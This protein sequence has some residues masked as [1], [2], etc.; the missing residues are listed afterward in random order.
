MAETLTPRFGFTHWGDSSTD[1]PSM[2]EFNNAFDALESL[3]AKDTQG[4]LAARPVAGE[5]QR[6]YFATD[7]DTLYRDNGSAWKVVGA[8]TV[9]EVV[10][11]STNAAVPM[12]VNAGAGQ[13]ADLLKAQVN[14][15]DKFAVDKD[16]KITAGAAA[17]ANVDITST[18]AATRGLRVT[19]HAAQSAD[20]ISARN[21][22]G[23]DQFAVSPTGAITS[24]F[25][26]A[27][28][29]KAV[30]GGTGFTTLAN[31]T[32]FTGQP[33]FEVRSTT[34]GTGTFNDSI[35][36]RHPQFDA[37]AV[38]RRV[39]LLLKLGDEI[40]GD[41]G[42]AGGIYLESVLANAATPK[43][44]LHRAD[45]D[46]MTFFPGA[47]AKI[48]GQGLI[49]EDVLDINK[50]AAP[51]IR[52]NTN[53]TQGAQGSSQ[54]NRVGSTADNFYFYAGGVHS[55]APGTAGAGGSTPAS[56]TGVGLW[57]SA[58]EILTS[59]ADA[60]LA[61]ASP[62][63]MVGAAGSAN[64]IASVSK[65]QARNNGAA[66]TLGLNLAGGEVQ[67][68][69]TSTDLKVNGGLR[70]HSNGYRFTI[71]ASAP[72]GPSVGDVWVDI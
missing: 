62:A 31:Q 32:L 9:D 40:G 6:Y 27:Q 63:F 47:Q 11:S 17:L 21:N 46:A 69:T 20:L 30:V 39:G 68:G 23:T 49:I 2:V 37:N 45:A 12:T 61:Q 29:D 64:L 72:G 65:V 50:T 51:S 19:G 15:V 70:L 33:A 25:F 60:T 35:V 4:L 42:K 52:F 36:L 66:A 22:A 34:G 38:S 7:N 48:H 26:T 28:Q 13:T 58:R 3:A 67:V 55:D 43:L 1:G 59:T 8:V 14:S 57:T 24:T 5:A 16:G 18:V 44:V 71:A 41:A 53:V 56:L 54:Y 10:R